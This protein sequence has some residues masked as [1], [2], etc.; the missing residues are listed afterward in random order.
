LIAQEQRIIANCIPF[1]E[2]GEEIPREQF[3]KQCSQGIMNILELHEQLTQPVYMSEEEAFHIETL[4]LLGTAR[5]YSE[6]VYE[7]LKTTEAKVLYGIGIASLI[8]GIIGLALHNIDFA[9]IAG[10]P[11]L[12][13]ALALLPLFYGIRRTRLRKR[14]KVG[15]QN[16]NILK[17]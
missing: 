1:D 2:F 13:V 15:R 4:K 8:A 5:I 3:E 9:I 7:L 10:I 12:I 17:Y 16:R 6:E 14:S 11:F